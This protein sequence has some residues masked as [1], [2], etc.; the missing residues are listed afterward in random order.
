MKKNMKKKWKPTNVWLG[1]C[2]LLSPL[3]LMLCFSKGIGLGM[4]C[5]F[6]YVP[7]WLPCAAGMMWEEPKPATCYFCGSKT[8]TSMFQ[9]ELGSIHHACNQHA[10]QAH[11]SGMRF[12]YLANRQ[13]AWQGPDNGGIA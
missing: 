9:T 11:A 5:L 8:V 7:I 4:F 12:T 1:I 2:I 6:F 10:H 3:L 13:K